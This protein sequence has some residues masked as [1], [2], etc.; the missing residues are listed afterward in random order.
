MTWFAGIL[1]ATIFDSNKSMLVR[2]RSS[3]VNLRYFL[4]QFSRV[5]ALST[6]Y[7]SQPEL[8]ATLPIEN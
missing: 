5:F 4:Y 7:V 8:S 6:N 1:R 2:E 3:H